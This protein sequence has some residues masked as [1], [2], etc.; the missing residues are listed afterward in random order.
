MTSSF[1][2]EH[3]AADFFVFRPPLLPFEELEAWSR[4][5]TA[6]QAVGAVD[7]RAAGASGGNGTLAGGLTLTNTA[8]SVSVT[9]LPSPQSQN[10]VLELVVSDD[11]SDP[12]DLEPDA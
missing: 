7:L 3:H 1:A 10:V 2:A 4:D 12:A 5:L 6:P 11:E 8:P 9:T